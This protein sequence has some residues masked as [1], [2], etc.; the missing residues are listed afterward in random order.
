MYTNICLNNNDNI[1]I[2]DT[3]AQH[4]YCY[5]GTYNAIHIVIVIALKW[6]EANILMIIVAG[7]CD[8]ITF[9][10]LITLKV[11]FI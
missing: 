10:S 7:A 9:E 5:I 8:L 4:H 2:D 6:K 11:G 1:T 3:R